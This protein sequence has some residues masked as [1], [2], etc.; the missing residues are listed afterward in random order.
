MIVFFFSDPDSDS[1]SNPS[2]L[3]LGSTAKLLRVLNAAGIFFNK[4]VNSTKCC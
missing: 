3:L 1:V 2:I 4:L